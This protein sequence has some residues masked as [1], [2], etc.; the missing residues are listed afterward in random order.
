MD[1][2]FISIQLL[3]Y[4]ACGGAFLFLAVLVALSRT[5]GRYKYLLLASCI[6]TVMW[7]A[8]VVG[9][10]W[11]GAWPRVN[12]ALD[13]ARYISWLV[14]L[15][16]LLGMR[17]I[18]DAGSTSRIAAAIVA[19]VGAGLL[20]AEPL[21]DA[22]M[23]QR[24][25][26]ML[27]LVSGGHVILAVIGLLALENLYRNAEPK[28]R[29][30]IK[31]FC[32]G[33]GTILG[34]DIFFYSDAAL[35][36]RANMTFFDAR[37]FV[38]ALAVPLLA[39]AV[40][41][42]TLWE[43]DIHV[44]RAAVFHSAALV[45]S[46]VY[47]ICMAAAGFYLKEFGGEWGGILQIL[48]LASAL[49]ILII[50][51]SSSSFRAKVK[52]WI[53]KHFFSY[54]YDYREEWLRFIRTVTS[55]ETGIGL[56]DRIL[57]S[58]ADIIQCDAGGLW[59]L[60]RED[61]AYLPT[62]LWHM[63]KRRPAVPAGSALVAF[64]EETHWIVNLDEYRQ[65]PARYRNVLLPD[66]ISDNERVWLIV[67]LIYRDSLQAFM[68]LGDPRAQ[69]AVDWE[70]F[71]L[72]RTVGHQAASYLAE[73][74]A[75]NELSD[76][77][78][79]QDFNRRSA[80]IIHDIKNVVSQMSLMMQNAERFGDNPEFQKDM[81]ATVS[82][83]VAR[84]K[85]LLER[86]RS[87][88]DEDG[89]GAADL[90]ALSVALRQVAKNWRRQKDDLKV[91]IDDTTTLLVDRE[92]FVSVLDHLLQNAI[93]AAGT[94]GGVTLRQIAAGDEIVIE[95]EDDGPGM[96]QE[97]VEAHL[98]RPLDSEKETGYGLGAYQTRQLVR[99]MGGRLDVVS[100]R[101]RGT[102]M[103]VILPVDAKQSRALRKQE[104]L[105]AA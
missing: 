7:A 12:A 90:I 64:L 8:S 74:Q 97:Y 34:F 41:R 61:D 102:T 27:T 89:V 75:M 45:V 13:V 72:L 73:Q 87:V 18:Q 38:N 42:A 80:F 44:S 24:P 58:L 93:E 62:A 100:E 55:A 66:W 46:G 37:G 79:L 88:Q 82:N 53:S 50:I 86:F 52:V 57:R 98:F 22:F 59:V 33:L 48:F 3:S 105:G 96:D 91:E 2:L 103:R 65:A 63:G 28:V 31:Y 1:A 71:D 4:L 35:L 20:L 9:V 11:F 54:K 32:F 60:R 36:G 104:E 39:I 51:F 49:L 101:G 40:S 26:G 81:L 15:G 16:A 6:L 92:K 56:H 10:Q 19:V 99:E 76:A 25:R 70:D 68:V 84:M 95:V 94:D 83:S 21:A 78:R 47:L 29:W 30:A 14:L 23:S 77:R 85:D 5:G 69:R 67:P 43:I 17:R